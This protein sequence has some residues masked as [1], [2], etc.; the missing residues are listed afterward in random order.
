MKKDHT[1]GAIQQ[2]YWICKRMNIWFCVTSAADPGC[3][4]RIPHLDFSI[5]DPDLQPWIY[6]EFTVSILN[7]SQKYDPRCWYG[8]RS[9]ISNLGSGFFPYPAPDLD[10]DPG[11]KGKKAIDPGSATHCDTMK[12]DWKQTMWRFR[13]FLCRSVTQNFKNNFRY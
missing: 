13:R 5:P 9:R 10:P 1:T 2:L 11:F 4:S 3:L 8:I 6:I 7:S 12:Y